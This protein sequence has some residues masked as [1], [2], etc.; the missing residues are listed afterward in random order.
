MQSQMYCLQQS[1]TITLSMSS[2][3][4]NLHLVVLS[5]ND[6]M[7]HKCALAGLVDTTNMKVL[8]KNGT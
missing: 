3:L 4:E 2:Q 8:D 1:D 6:N 5:I 7:K